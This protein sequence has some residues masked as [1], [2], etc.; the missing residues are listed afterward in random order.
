[1]SVMNILGHVNKETLLYVQTVAV[2][3]CG[4]GIFTGP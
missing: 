2:E 4:C 1:M 3:G